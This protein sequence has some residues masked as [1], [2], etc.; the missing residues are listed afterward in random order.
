MTRPRGAGLEDVA[1]NL[2]LLSFNDA[3]LDTWTGRR[4][5][6]LRRL[7]DLPADVA[8]AVAEGGSLPLPATELRPVLAC[9][10]DDALPA[11]T[12]G[13]REDLERLKDDVMADHGHPPGAKGRFPLSEERRRRLQD[14]PRS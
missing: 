8:G 5:L 11:L 7:G 6:V 1:W 10:T 14:I 13:Q 4:L 2:S 9:L 12:A 3:Y